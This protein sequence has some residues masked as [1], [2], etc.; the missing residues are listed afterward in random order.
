MS[1]IKRLLNAWGE[2]NERVKAEERQ[3]A[4]AREQEKMGLPVIFACGCG[5][6]DCSGQLKVIPMLVGGIR[7]VD[8]YQ[9][10]PGG[11]VLSPGDREQLRAILADPQWFGDHA[12]LR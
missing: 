1:V 12:D 5:R 6:E 9:L 7:S 2:A 11:V 10:G 3:Q 8:L 4:R